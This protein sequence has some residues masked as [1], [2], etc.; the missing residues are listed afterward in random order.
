MAVI[1]N[2]NTT[3]TPMTTTGVTGVQVIKFIPASRV[4]LKAPD[5]VTAAPVNTMA[6]YSNKSNGATPAGFTDLGI[7]NQDAKI[8]YTKN[9]KKVQTGL[10]KFVQAVYVGDKTCVIE[11]SLSQMD[12]YL[13]AQLGFTTSTIT[14]GSSVN[15]QIGQEDVIAKAMIM[16]FQNKLDGKEIQWYHPAAQL[17]VTFDSKPEEAAVKVSA[18]CIAFTAAGGYTIQSLLSATIFA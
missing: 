15:F 14:A 13:M 7:M 2:R 3:Q 4:Y 9:V 8:T 1:V 6:A 18:D 10:D 12:E 11:F 16:V 17:T 5:S